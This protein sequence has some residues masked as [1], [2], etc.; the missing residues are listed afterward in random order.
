MTVFMLTQGNLGKVPALLIKN[1]T[2]SLLIK[3]IITSSELLT[4][5][6]EKKKKKLTGCIHVCHL[7][8]SSDVVP[9]EAKGHLC[10]HLWEQ[11]IK[12]RGS[13]DNFAVA[14]LLVWAL[15]RSCQFK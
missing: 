6:I 8:T 4:Q 5:E 2:Y 10:N 9:P 13:W 12:I 1:C 3:I 11:Y 7:I 14:L 15:L